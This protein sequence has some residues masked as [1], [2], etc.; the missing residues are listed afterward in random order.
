MA[1]PQQQQHLLPVLQP[2]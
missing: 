1:V 2:H